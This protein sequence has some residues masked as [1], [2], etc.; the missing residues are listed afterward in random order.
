[1]PRSFE[2]TFS[3]VRPRFFQPSMMVARRRG[4]QRF[5]SIFS[6]LM[7]C[8]I[9]RKL[10]SPSRIVK[11][12]LRSAISA[13][14]RRIFT[15]MEWKV[16]SHGMPSTMPP[17]IAPMRFFIS[18][19]ALLVKVTARISLGRAL[20]VARICPMRVVRTRVLPVPAPASTK[21]G[22]SVVRTASACSSLSPF[23]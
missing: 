23:K 18:L 8:F 4:G 14:L 5:S 3:G 22:P 9:K 16:P 6:A 17:I 21:T 12:D 11:L 7:S 1:M 15:P 20:P 10:S 2:G 19:V 13:C